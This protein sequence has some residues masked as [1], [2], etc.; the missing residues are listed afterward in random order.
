MQKIVWIDEKDIKIIW[1]EGKPYVEDDR[2]WNGL[3]PLAP[4]EMEALE[5]HD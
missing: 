4:H 5:Y 3:R 2:Y 1:H